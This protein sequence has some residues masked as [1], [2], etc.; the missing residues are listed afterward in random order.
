MFTQLHPDQKEKTQPYGKTSNK[1]KISL[2]F[3]VDTLT[4]LFSV[5][6]KKK[7]SK[8]NVKAS[9]IDNYSRIVF[10]ILFFAFHIIYWTYYLTISTTMWHKVED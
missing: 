10:P 2:D 6:W 7:F 9:T 1:I 4:D 8:V 3:Y 5:D